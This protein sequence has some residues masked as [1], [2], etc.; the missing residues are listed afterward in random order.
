MVLDIEHPISFGVHTFS[1]S[2]SKFRKINS[3]FQRIKFYKGINELSISIA[4]NTFS[5]S[6][7][8][9]VK[10]NI[11]FYWWCMFN[12]CLVVRW[13]QVYAFPD[14][15]PFKNMWTLVEV[16]KAMSYVSQSNIVF[17]SFL[18]NSGWIQRYCQ[19]FSNTCCFTPYSSFLSNVEWIQEL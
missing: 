6:V 8:R 14:L 7:S 16:L 3:D 17:N 10:F 11:S 12:N 5:S 1:S 2:V 9:F 13:I 19:W 15:I 18:S 4:L